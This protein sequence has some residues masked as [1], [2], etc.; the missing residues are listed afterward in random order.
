MSHRA[1]TPRPTALTTDG[2]LLYACTPDG[3]LP[4]YLYAPLRSAVLCGQ[5]VPFASHWPEH[6]K[7]FVYSYHPLLRLTGDGLPPEHARHIGWQPRNPNGLRPN[8]QTL[9]KGWPLYTA[10]RDTPG[11]PPRSD[12]PDLFQPVTLTTEPLPNHNAGLTRHQPPPIGP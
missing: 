5:G 10:H 11:D 4:L 12:F 9:Y 7:L 1:R 8:D 3:P 2:T 6:L